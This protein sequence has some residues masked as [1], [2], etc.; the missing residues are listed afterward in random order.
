MRK[1]GS[2]HIGKLISEKMKEQ[3][4]SPS[5]LAGKIGCKR[6]TIYSI[7]N[8]PNTDIE[9]LKKIAL[10]LGYNFFLDLAHNLAHNIDMI[11]QDKKHLAIVE[12]TGPELEKLK[13]SCSNC[14]LTVPLSN[15]SL[16]K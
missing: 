7:L 9:K 6:T 5:K 8:N 2:I 3:G 15:H 14:I 16:T 1:D 12:V 11:E 10:A 4:L 13:Q